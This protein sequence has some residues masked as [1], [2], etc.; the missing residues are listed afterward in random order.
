ML[1]SLVCPMRN[2][3]CRPAHPCKLCSNGK[4]KLLQQ[5]NGKRKRTKTEQAVKLND[6][7]REILRW[8]P[9]QLEFVDPG[10]LKPLPL[11]MDSWEDYRASVL[12]L[13]REEC[14]AQIWQDL[15]LYLKSQLQIRPDGNISEPA[16]GCCYFVDRFMAISNGNF[17]LVTEMHLLTSPGQVIIPLSKI[18]QDHD[19]V[20]V[21]AAKQSKTIFSLHE[22]LDVCFGIVGAVQAYSNKNQLRVKMRSVSGSVYVVKISSLTSIIREWEGVEALKTSS[23]RKYILRPSM[24][25]EPDRQIVRKIHDDLPTFPRKNLNPSQRYAVSM[26]LASTG[27]TLIQGPPGCG[28]TRTIEELLCAILAGFAKN[29]T[30]ETNPKVLCC[31]P[32]NAAIDEVAVRVMARMQSNFGLLRIGSYNYAEKGDSKAKEIHIDTLI[33]NYYEKKKYKQGQNLAKR[34]DIIF[35]TLSS[36]GLQVLNDIAF[37]FI[38]VDESTQSVEPS[39]LIPLRFKAKAYVLVGDPQQLPATVISNVDQYKCS[40]FERFMKNGVKPC[41]L[42]VQYRMHEEIRKFPSLTF[43]DD[44]LQ[45]GPNIPERKDLAVYF[46][47]DLRL[48]PYLVFDCLHGKEQKSYRYSSSVENVEEAFLVARIV[49][50]L[51]QYFSQQTPGFMPSSKIAICTPYRGQIGCIRQQLNRLKIPGCWDIYINTVDGFQGQEREIIVFSAVRTNMMGFLEDTRR[52][53]VA[54][55]RARNAL[56]IVG[57][58]RRLKTNETWNRLFVDARKRGL[59]REVR[60]RSDVHSMFH[61]PAKY[62]SPQEIEKI[63]AAKEAKYFKEWWHCETDNKRRA[64]IFET[65]REKQRK[66]QLEEERVRKK[67]Q[68]RLYLDLSNGFRVQGPAHTTM[69]HF[70]Y[71]FR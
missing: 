56:F 20:I 49:H 47:K 2:V 40:L 23:F 52:L 50:F 65:R 41:L 48:G 30:S 11:S 54:I 9:L 55:T 68:E 62:V 21:F 5:Q 3:T 64:K 61:Q 10:P 24:N 28:K 60:S 42:D 22:E 31:A 16:N 27:F 43:Y 35:T 70:S 66:K 53:N 19:L 45:D 63:I 14:R 15:A 34:S 51:T 8:N 4:R 13:I 29:G 38:V 57:N 37:D 39:T 46:T 36:A 1:S 26:S 69:P 59:I 6:L 18:Y 12:P 25:P 32:S 67:A 71:G 58:S 17:G 7:D 33:P 44:K